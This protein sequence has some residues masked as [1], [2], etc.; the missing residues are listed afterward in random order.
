MGK[1]IHRIKQRSHNKYT[2]TFRRQVE[3]YKAFEKT[4]VF[5]YRNRS[6][7]KIFAQAHDE[8]VYFGFHRTCETITAKYFFKKFTRRFRRYIHHCH[9]CNF[10]NTKRHR[11]NSVFSS[12]M[13]PPI[14]Q[15]TVTINFIFGFPTTTNGMDA[16]ISIICKKFKLA[17]ILP[18]K[19]IYIAENWVI[20]FWQQNKLSDT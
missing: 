14:P 9:E 17:T 1:N 5:V 16:G 13:T 15:H 11:P 10:N 20:F 2:I 8:N 3:F 4:T 12:I 19:S 18:G 6:R 7:K